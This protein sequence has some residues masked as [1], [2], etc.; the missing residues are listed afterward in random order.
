MAQQI[1]QDAKNIEKKLLDIFTSDNFEDI[2]EEK[3][4]SD[5]WEYIYH[6]SPIRQNIIS[7]F[8][9]KDDSNVLEV[10]AGCGAITPGIAN[11]R[12]NLTS[13]E[14]MPDRYKV[15][16]EKV[17]KL[18]LPNTKT[19]Q[20]SSSEF[21][22]EN[23]IFDYIV[24]IG[25]L[26]YSG[27]FISSKNPY[28]SF[29]EEMHSLLEDQ[30]TLILA[31]ENKF[32]LKY[33]SGMPEDHVNRPFEG[34]EDYISKYDD[35]YKG[36]KTFSNLELKN[37]LTEAGFENFKFYYPLPDYKFPT[38]IFS[39]D[40]LPNDNH[41]IGASSLY[42]KQHKDFKRLFNMNRT[43]ASIIENNMFSF[44]SNSFLVTAQKI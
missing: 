15:L 33:W 42:E 10:G 12:Y 5:E 2:I 40:Y 21:I 7:W 28:I 11:P 30:G 6:L 39:D 4:N 43:M 32:G 34:I 37:I 18:K 38:E 26:E 13:I 14:P 23:K 29:L 17:K 9:F 44:F 19:L 31:I 22:S 41:L 8:D 25:V 20:K 1:Y 35:R 27:K 36:V 3:L 24:C 16:E